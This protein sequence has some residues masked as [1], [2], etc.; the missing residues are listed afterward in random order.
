ME[1]AALD[2]HPGDDG[3]GMGIGH[4]LQSLHVIGGPAKVGFMLQRHGAA[5]RP[6]LLHL[7]PVADLLSKRD[8]RPRLR[9]VQYP[10]ALAAQGVAQRVV[11][12]RL[13][14]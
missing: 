7:G 12:R 11:G 10:L 14:P 3:D 13:L 1:E 9:T 4:A 2:T 5:I 8:Q 6:H